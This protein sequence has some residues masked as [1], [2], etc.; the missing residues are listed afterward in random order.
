M[1]GPRPK[2]HFKTKKMEEVQKESHHSKTKNNKTE[3]WGI[4]KKGKRKK[5]VGKLTGARN[6]NYNNFGVLGGGEGEKKVPCKPLTGETCK[7]TTTFQGNS[8]R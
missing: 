7:K 5:R 1:G 6:K 8:T 3:R 4:K 2:K